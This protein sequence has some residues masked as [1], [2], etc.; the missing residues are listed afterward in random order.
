[1]IDR[2]GEKAEHAWEAVD[3]YLPR[4]HGLSPTPGGRRGSDVSRLSV[5]SYSSAPRTLTDGRFVVHPSPAS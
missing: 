3:G 4:G 1:M 2:A 5:C